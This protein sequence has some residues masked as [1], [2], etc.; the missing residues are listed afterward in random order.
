MQEAIIA[1]A[2]ENGVDVP[3]LCEAVEF[4]WSQRSE[5]ATSWEAA[6]AGARQ[7]TRLDRGRINKWED[8]GRDSAS[9][10]GL[11]ANAREAASMFPELGIGRG[12]ETGGGCDDTDY[13]GRLWGILREGRRPPPRRHDPALIAEA[14]RL[15]QAK[16]VV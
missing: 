15:I 9:W 2:A 16:A 11:D 10:P 7:I 12:Y 14:I 3:A 1:A 6:K 13:A 4:V 8:A 5:A